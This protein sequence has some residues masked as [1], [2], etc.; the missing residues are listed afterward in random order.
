MGDYTPTAAIFMPRPNQ[1]NHFQFQFFFCFL[2]VVER[3]LY[4]F[5]FRNNFI[6]QARNFSR[7]IQVLVCLTYKLY[8]SVK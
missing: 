5:D 4:I 7:S 6:I 8:L 1:K 3:I 2:F